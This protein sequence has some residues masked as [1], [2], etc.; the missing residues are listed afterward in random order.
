LYA[1]YLSSM[2]LDQQWVSSCVG[3]E[4]NGR[5]KYIDERYLAY[6][7]LHAP[8]IDLYSDLR[9]PWVV[10]TWEDYL[11]KLF[12]SCAKTKKS[13]SH[14][15]AWFAKKEHVNIPDFSTAPARIDMLTNVKVWNKLYALGDQDESAIHPVRYMNWCKRSNSFE[16]T[17]F[18]LRPIIDGLKGGVNYLKLLLVPDLERYFGVNFGFKKDKPYRASGPTLMFKTIEPDSEELWVALLIAHDLCRMWPSQAEA[19]YF[20][21]TLKNAV[22]K[23]KERECWDEQADAEIKSLFWAR[24]IQKSCL[25]TF[26]SMSCMVHNR[27]ETAHTASDSMIAKA[28]T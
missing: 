20:A 19:L 16:D 24:I 6:K 11:Y 23:V 25:I 7:A 21:R 26:L 27:H 14:L 15:E 4:E 17:M 9:V 10:E 1:R 2:Y 28:N 8:A 5:S 12:E 13:S 22:L 3:Y 18:F